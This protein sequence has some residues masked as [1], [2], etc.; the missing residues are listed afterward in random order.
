MILPYLEFLNSKQLV[1]ASQSPRRLQILKQIGLQFTVN[2]SR[3]EENLDKSAMTPME[4]VMANA[5]EKAKEVYN[6]MKQEQNGKAPDLVIGCD[7]IVVL[8][9]K[10]LEKPRSE[11][12]AKSML[13]EL[14]GRSHDVLSGVALISHLKNETNPS[15]YVFSEKTE[16]HFA[17]LSPALIDAYVA[18]K[19]PMDKAGAYGIQ[20]IG[21]CLISGI[22]GCYYN[23]AI[24][25]E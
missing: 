19:E 6:R 17:E 21:G 12:S 18:T 2:V 9:E 15:I 1:L 22:D 11:E 23:V 25:R 16:V 14:S 13:S 20:G 7:T 5:H 10:I 3:F 8:D 24:L 4:Y